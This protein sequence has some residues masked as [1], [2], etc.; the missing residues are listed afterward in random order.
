L[1]FDFEKTVADSGADK[2]AVWQKVEP[3]PQ[4][5]I[6]GILNTLQAQ[7][8]AFINDWRSRL[9]VEINVLLVPLLG[10]QLIDWSSYSFENIFGIRLLLDACKNQ[11][12]SAF[13]T[14]VGA[15]GLEAFKLPFNLKLRELVGDTFNTANTLNLEALVAGYAFLLD[16]MCAPDDLNCLSNRLNQ[17]AAQS[18]TAYAAMNAALKEK[19]I[20]TVADFVG[21]PYTG[22][23]PSGS[24][25]SMPNG[26]AWDIYTV[27]ARYLYEHVPFR[28]HRQAAATKAINM[29]NGADTIIDDFAGS[30]TDSARFISLALHAGGIPM[31]V[32]P[33]ETECR[34]DL[35]DLPVQSWCAKQVGEQYEANRTW[36][37]HNSVTDTE[38]SPIPNLLDDKRLVGYLLG[39]PEVLG[40]GITFQN[41][42]LYEFI[43][44]EEII[45]KPTDLYA[46]SSYGDT[47]P[48]SQQLPTLAPPIYDVYGNSGFVGRVEQVMQRLSYFDVGDYIF[49]G[50]AQEHGFLIVNKLNIV[51]CESGVHLSPS[52]VFWGADL[53]GEQV[54]TPRPFYC[55]R[56]VEIDPNTGQPKTDQNGRVKFFAARYWY[57]IKVSDAMW[58]AFDRLYKNDPF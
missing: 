56:L 51:N 30:G 12:G 36:L 18:Y 40:E 52:E 55:S 15:I 31:T 47:F 16:G 24:E 10:T 1:G 49:T 19:I 54:G 5:D 8:T 48:N 57:F 43:S 33:N 45:G 2:W 7:Y 4:G 58:V 9:I 32:R 38:G 39:N 6:T 41:P 14:C 42:G 25:F 28:Y 22:R 20:A 53:P 29:A 37:V 26:V 44:V 34:T 46:S 50:G 17:P 23:H 35:N 21:F 13:F 3:L 27:T 11:T